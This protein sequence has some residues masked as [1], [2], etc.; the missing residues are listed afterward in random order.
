VVVA[1]GVAASAA[2]VAVAVIP[3][4]EEGTPALMAPRRPLIWPVSRRLRE[5]QH[6]PR[7]RDNEF[8]TKRATCATTVAITTITIARR[9]CYRRLAMIATQRYPRIVTPSR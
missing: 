7:S 8:F 3:V 9:T 5:K 4:G 6:V 2:A 1:A